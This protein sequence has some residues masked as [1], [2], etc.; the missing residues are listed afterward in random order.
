M[1][2][3]LDFWRYG[4]GFALRPLRRIFQCQ[5]VRDAMSDVV[6]EGV[7]K[8]GSSEVKS[9]IGRL[10]GIISA[11]ELDQMQ[12]SGPAA[13][14][15]TLT[16]LWLMVLQRL[17]GGLS[18]QAVLKEAIAHAED[19]FPACK[20]VRQATLSGRDTAFSDAR[21]RLEIS[22]VR[23]LYRSVNGSLI[24]AC[25]V[26]GERPT[27]LIDGTT[28]T[29]APTEDLKQAFP[30]ATNQ[31]GQSV[32]PTVLMLN[33]H[34][35]RSGCS[36]AFELGAMYGDRATCEAA[37]LPAL[38][39]QLPPEAIAVADAGFG[40]FAPVRDCITAGLSV[41]FR[42]SS[43]QYQ[44][45]IKQ[46]TLLMQP[47]PGESYEL[48]WKP[49]ANNLRTHP[50]ISAAET[51][52]VVLHKVR[53][54]EILPGCPT[55]KW[56]YMVTT[57]DISR[58]QAIAVYLRRYDIEHDIRDV[59]VTLNTERIRV[60]TREMFEKEL[61]TSLVAYNL[62]IQFRREAALKAGVAPRR[63]SFTGVWNT[64]QSFLL[65]MSP[66]TTA[67]QWEARYE[68][69]L[70]IASKEILRI[71]PHRSYPRQAHPRRPKTTQSQ[72]NQRK[73]HSQ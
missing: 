59:K 35:L 61:L 44:S 67:E 50:H 2:P 64:M 3:G 39:H 10:R 63:L 40:T 20:R 69:A 6:T 36:A 26:S 9:M 45:L 41:I 42:M 23:H 18:M 21:Q 38:C 53:F 14:Y 55:E 72:K 47:G 62:V 54:S 31:H 71:R 13:V 33:A 17:G 51:L 37:L 46:A 52:E 4:T 25:A 34:E 49:T 27:F 5:N 58:R 29:T 8:P 24:Q 65:R 15:T 60:H 32:W 66:S 68:R 56:L 73:K 7:S 43:H 22:T 70:E 28:L 19:I 1:A 30:P 48:T 12:P 16:T 57:P 11:E